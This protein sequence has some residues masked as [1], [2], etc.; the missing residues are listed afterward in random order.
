VLRRSN[1]GVLYGDEYGGLYTARA[2]T[3][4]VGQTIRW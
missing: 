1:K 2:G 3:G 4:S